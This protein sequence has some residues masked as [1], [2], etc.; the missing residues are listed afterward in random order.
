M[1][2][3]ATLAAAAS[4]LTLEHPNF[5]EF[6]E[7]Q[8][9]VSKAYQSEGHEMRGFQNWLVS[10]QFVMEHNIKAFT[11]Q[12]SFTVEMNQFADLSDEEWVEYN[13]LRNGAKANSDCKPMP[14]SSAEANPDSVDWRNE[15]YV[16]PI[17]DQG[18]CGSCWAFSTT[19][20]T[21]G[22]HFK[23][24][25][26]LVT[27]SEQQLVDCSTKEGDHGCNGGLMDFGFTYIIENDGITT[28]SAYPYKAQD[29]SCKS[30]M[31]AAATLSE[32]YDV[33]QGSEADLET[34]VATVGPISVAIDAHLLSFRLYKQGIYHDRLCSST[35]LDHGV[36]AVGYKN[37]PSGNYWIVK[38]SWNTTWGNEGY[39]W[40]AK[41][42]KN[43]C[44]IA[45][46]A[47]YP[48]A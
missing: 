35:R 44:G 20:S 31:T 29:G 46:A 34:A 3:F 38:N 2:L 11:G 42:K 8:A 18:Q 30:G 19:G 10:R 15:G 22:A 48:V 39:I 23:K 47:S 40:M 12:E 33:A 9:K 21:E 41:D 16:T 5:Q 28:E 25:G 43:T 37:D 32:C 17:K 4:A 6:K 13:R 27:L 45:T 14:S 1:K 36:L 24:T 7:W 26:K